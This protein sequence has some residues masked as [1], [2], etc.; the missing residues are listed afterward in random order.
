[1]KAASEM[2]E[3]CASNARVA[4][5]QLDQAQKKLALHSPGE[6]DHAEARYL[7][8]RYTAERAHWLEYEA[9]YRQRAEDQPVA[10]SP[11]AARPLR[12]RPV[13]VPERR[14]PREEDDDELPF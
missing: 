2:V 10:E 4:Q 5:V 1:M 7:I 6:P 11:P 3:A 9:F 12:P 13:L 8:R 14:L